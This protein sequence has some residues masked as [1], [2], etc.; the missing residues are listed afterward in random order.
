[1]KKFVSGVIVGALLFAGTSVFADS[2]GLIGQKVQGLFTIEKAGVKVSDAVII[3]GSAY[4]PVRAVADATGSDLKVEGKKIIMLVEGKVPAEVEISRLN[5]SVDLKKQQIKT[6]QESIADIQSKIAK[7]E[8]NIEASTSESNKEI[9]QFNVNEYTKQIT[10]MQTKLDAANSEIAELQ[11]QI[12][13][14]QK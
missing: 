14:L 12:N 4:A 9:F 1:M 8:K 5:I 2:V 11:A 3:N 7:E 13:Q 6:Y 10:S